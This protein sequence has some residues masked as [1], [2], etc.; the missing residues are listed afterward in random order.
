MIFKNTIS[1]IIECVC[2]SC[3][4]RFFIGVI[5]GGTVTCPDCGFPYE[6]VK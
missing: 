5:D 4:S 3:G 6:V 1:K 2:V